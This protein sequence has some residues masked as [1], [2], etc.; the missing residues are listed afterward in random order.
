LKTIILSLLLGVSSG[1]WAYPE[2]VRHGYT[3]CIAC[4]IS[5]SGGGILTPYGKSLASELLTYNWSKTVKSNE[6]KKSADPAADAV[7][8]TWLT[9]GDARVLLFHRNNEYENSY[10]MIPMQVDVNGAYNAD[11]YAFVLGVGFSGSKP[12]SEEGATA[13][14]IPNAFGLFRITDELNVRAGLFLPAYGLNNSLHTIATRAPLGFGFKDQRMGIELS[15]LAE[16]WG[17]FVSQFGNRGDNLGDNAMTAQLQYSPTEKSKFAINYWSE[18]NLRTIYGAWFVT[19]IYGPL[20][21]SA[22]YESQKETLTDT[23]GLFYFAKIGYELSQGMHFYLESDHA[24]RDL[25]RNYTKVE[26]YGPGFQFFPAVNWELDAVW[27]REK[28]LTY[29]KKEA[30]YA[31]IMA[32]YY[33]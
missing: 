6:E 19:P 7:I 10:Q 13:F 11:K 20:Y 2:M 32:H 29:S 3:N 4:H 25:D 21:I 14:R 26:R 17:V 33:L 27:L 8:S 22:D 31:Y 28:N 9:G 12:T 5:P 1:A 23:K 15:Y 18:N 16:K 24:Q 30:D